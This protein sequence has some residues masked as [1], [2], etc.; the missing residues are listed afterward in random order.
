MI[1]SKDKRWKSKCEPLDKEDSF[2]KE[3][4]EKEA[5]RIEFWK[6]E[7]AFDLKGL[8]EDYKATDEIS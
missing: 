2:L 7:K 5:R 1:Q 4:P 8:T 3:L 6:K